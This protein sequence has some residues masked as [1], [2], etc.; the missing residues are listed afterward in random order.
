MNQIKTPPIK[1]IHSPS[2]AF[3][4]LLLCGIDI[5]PLNWFV[6]GQKKEVV[7]YHSILT[8]AQT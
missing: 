5:W 4:I 6:I 7:F 1:H 3:N 8:Q 2:N